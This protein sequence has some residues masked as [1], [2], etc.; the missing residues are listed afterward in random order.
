VLGTVDPWWE[1]KAAHADYYQYI[2]HIN[3]EDYE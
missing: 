3:E 2:S 1:Y